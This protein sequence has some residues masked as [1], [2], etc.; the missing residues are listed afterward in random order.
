MVIQNHEV[1]VSYLKT[2]TDKKVAEVAWTIADKIRGAVLPYRQSITC[3][4]AAYMLYKASTANKVV[5]YSDFTS[6]KVKMPGNLALLIP[7]LVNEALWQKLAP[8]AKEHDS[9][10]FA[11]VVLGF[12]NMDDSFVVGDDI[13]TP[14]SLCDLS[15]KL[16]HL[17]DGDAVMDLGSGPANMLLALLRQDVKVRYYGYEIASEAA[18]IA[19]ARLDAAKVDGAVHQCDVFDLVGESLKGALPKDKARKVFS[20]FPFFVRYEDREFPFLTEI[21][22]ECEAFAKRTSFNWVFCELI[23]RVM[24]EQGRGIGI[25]VNGDLTNF[26]SLAVREHFLKRGLIECVVSLPTKLFDGTSI[27]CALVIFSRGNT[28]VRFVDASGI[29]SV[30]RRR[31]LFSAEDIAKIVELVENGGE[32]C[33]DVG[34]DVLA[35]TDYILNPTQ[36]AVPEED[37]V[38]FEDFILKSTRGAPCKASDLDKMSS[39]EPTDYRFLTLADIKN[40]VVSDSLPYLSGIERSLEK[41][42]IK[43]NSLIMSK[44]GYPYKVA[45]VTVPE[46]KKVLANGNLFVIELDETKANP[47][48]VKAYFE[49]GRGIAALK[50]I[51]SGTAMPMISIDLLRKLRIPLPS[52]SEQNAFV[53]RY[54][55]GVEKV[56]KLRVQLDEAL[57]SLSSMFDAEVNG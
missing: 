3:N 23:C 29:H 37:G 49:S 2:K 34:I 6:G 48:F 14:A 42:C 36:Y 32:G 4:L 51:T 22:G 9:D 38:T 57:A 8:L 19:A 52:L 47:M 27:S 41:F 30:G 25:V 46:G 20:N 45:V 12:G 44:N 18:D 15:A 40:G 21:K 26:S 35:E 39:Q 13:A 17:V 53:A 54:L 33:R 43:N 10:V 55:K 31:N 11:S 16:L 28:S 50:R 24:G 7:N 56:A 5:A 1:L